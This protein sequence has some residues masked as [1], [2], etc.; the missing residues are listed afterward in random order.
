[1]FTEFLAKVSSIRTSLGLSVLCQNCKWSD[2]CDL[3]LC[4]CRQ[5]KKNLATWERTLQFMV[6]SF[7]LLN[8]VPQKTRH[9]ACM[10]E[11]RKPAVALTKQLSKL[12]A[13]EKVTISFKHYKLRGSVKLNPATKIL[14]LLLMSETY[15]NLSLEQISHFS[16]TH[17]LCQSVLST[18]CLKLYP[19]FHKGNGT[20]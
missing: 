19:H 14:L 6:S 13:L 16:P 11:Y 10:H 18:F 5:I 1:M 9:A 2:L 4:S 20:H 17:V 12:V 15:K 7:C 8:S 3:G